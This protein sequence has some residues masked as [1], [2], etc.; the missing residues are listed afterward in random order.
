[1][2]FCVGWGFGL[3]ESFWPLPFVRPGCP[4]PSPLPLLTGVLGE[5]GR[6]MIAMIWNDLNDGVW[7]FWFLGWVALL[8]VWGARPVCPPRLPSP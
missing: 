8:L 2:G 1:M 3:G 7:L 5:G 4:H 6:T